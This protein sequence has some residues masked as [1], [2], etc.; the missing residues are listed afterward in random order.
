MHDDEV[1]TAAVAVS[2]APRILAPEYAAAKHP[3][4]PRAVEAP[5]VRPEDPVS[6]MRHYDR[7]RPRR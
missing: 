7:L 2:P 3:I 6:V 1:L 4:L 5:E